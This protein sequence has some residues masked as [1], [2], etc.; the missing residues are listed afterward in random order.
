M[1]IIILP[2]TFTS[3]VDN[4]LSTFPDGLDNY[5]LTLNESGLWFMLN[6]TTYALPELMHTFASIQ[7][8]HGTDP[9][10]SITITKVS[11]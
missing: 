4:A 11:L 3:I 5:K 9:A 1:P 2:Q 10:K 6:N 7:L 8:V